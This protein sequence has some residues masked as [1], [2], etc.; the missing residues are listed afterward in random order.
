M[1]R[2]SECNQ[3]PRVIVLA[4]DDSRNPG[5]VCP[6]CQYLSRDSKDS[7]SIREHGACTEC[8]TNF[9]HLMA[10]EWDKG[11]RPTV[12]VARSKMHGI[13]KA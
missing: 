5:L 10:T 9:R 6:V 4:D 7:Q 2:S 3:E 11:V 12:E 1:R 13:I 8:Y